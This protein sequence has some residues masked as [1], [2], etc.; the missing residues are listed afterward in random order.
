LNYRYPE[1]RDP[2]AGIKIRKRGFEEKAK[3]YCIAINVFGTSMAYREK[4]QEISGNSCEHL[5]KRREP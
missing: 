4:L 5:T 1:G 3:I 2:L